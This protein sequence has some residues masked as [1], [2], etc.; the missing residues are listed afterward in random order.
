MPLLIA[1]GVLYFIVGVAILIISFVEKEA[2][3][4]IMNLED[5]VWMSSDKLKKKKK[6]KEGE[7]RR[8]R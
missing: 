1:L 4:K 3:E 8:K 6:K 5:M 7:S 2:L